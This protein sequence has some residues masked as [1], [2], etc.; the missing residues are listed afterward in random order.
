MPRRFS[1]EDATAC[2]VVTSTGRWVCEGWIDTIIPSSS[3]PNFI[4]FSIIAQTNPRIA[5]SSVPTRSSGEG[6][7]FGQTPTSY[8]NTDDPKHLEFGMEYCSNDR[9]L[10]KFDKIHINEQN[11]ATS[12]DSAWIRGRQCTDRVNGHSAGYIRIR[13]QG[14]S[15]H[16][17]WQPHEFGC[18]RILNLL[19]KP[20]WRIGSICTPDENSNE[21]KSNQ[22]S[23]HVW[24]VMTSEIISDQNFGLYK[25]SNMHMGTWRIR[26][27][28]FLTRLKIC[29]TGD[30]I[31]PLG[32]YFSKI[33]T[34]C[35]QTKDV[36]EWVMCSRERKR[37]SVLG[38]LDGEINYVSELARFLLSF[39]SSS[40]FNGYSLWGV[41]WSSAR[42]KQLQ[43]HWNF[44][45]FR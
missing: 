1:I 34:G 18:T 7:I 42:S 2:T 20:K 41:F 21:Y 24:R 40:L 22:Q 36:L 5:F 16:L 12:R 11:H 6:G 15:S 19:F 9:R 43:I 37:V 29:S 25:W 14:K 45:K 26:F 39:S 33:W 23:Q 32:T 17:F 31:W 10:T 38:W 44:L 3:S 27:S 4:N 30:W 35:V 8:S 28:F 13:V